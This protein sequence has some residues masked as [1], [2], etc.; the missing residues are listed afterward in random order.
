MDKLF[1]L[2]PYNQGRLLLGIFSY[3]S[4]LVNQYVAKGML[5]SPDDLQIDTIEDQRFLKGLVGDMI[6]ELIEANETYVKNVELYNTRGHELIIGSPTF[7][8]EARDLVLEN[9]KDFDEE[10]ADVMH[11]F[12]ELMLY[13]RIEPSDISD[14]YISK[15]PDFMVE[16]VSE[17]LGQSLFMAKNFVSA[18]RE[19]STIK[20]N[21]YQPLI[22][23]LVMPG[24][25][26]SQ[27]VYTATKIISYD[28]IR[29]LKAITYRLKNKYWRSTNTST[30][31]KEYQTAI[32]EAWESWIFYL[33][34]MGIDEKQIYRSYEMKNF[35]NQ[36]RIIDGY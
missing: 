3:Q 29:A 5:K 33:V 11:F 26:I 21:S 18:Q 34:F 13:S 8:N 16:A 19:L 28:F 22:T 15:Y 27:E 6:Q 12:I 7:S 10:L 1:K 31:A 36:N 25:F 2:E 30:H 9:L 17:P 23:G 14:Y 32:M 20:F 24:R 4:N 35:I